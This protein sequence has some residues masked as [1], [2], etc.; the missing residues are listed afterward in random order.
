MQLCTNES[1]YK[2]TCSTN[3]DILGQNTSSLRWIGL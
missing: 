2:E 1:F 3:N